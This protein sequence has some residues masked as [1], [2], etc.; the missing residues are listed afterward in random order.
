MYYI[1]KVKF[2]NIDE[3]GKIKKMYEQYLVEALS[4]SDAEEKLINRFKES[5]SEFGVVSVVESK[6][7]GVIN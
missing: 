3:S 6:I 7:L 1:A 4:V 2:E 5:I